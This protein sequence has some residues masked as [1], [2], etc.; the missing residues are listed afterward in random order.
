MKE[1]TIR[2]H[3]D[4]DFEEKFWGNVTVNESTGCWEWKGHR[5]SNGEYGYG[6]AVIGGL[7]GYAHRIA[8]LLSGGTLR[9]G[10]WVLH[11]CDNPP[12]INPAHLSDGTPTEN[13]RDRE[14]KGRGRY[15]EKKVG[16]RSV[17]PHGHLF[18]PGNPGRNRRGAAVCRVCDRERHRKT[19]AESN[20]TMP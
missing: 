15:S 8:W 1:I 6:T 7:R 4:D 16:P 3:V 19:S 9:R 5:I 18:G 20:L 12:C 10:K 13:A 2:L 17:C 11:S 14:R